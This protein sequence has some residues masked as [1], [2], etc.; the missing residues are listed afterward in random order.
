MIL[1][2]FS[3]CGFFVDHR[4]NNPSSLF[5]KTGHP[6]TG[7]FSFVKAAYAVHDGAANEYV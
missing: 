6:A 3:F 4:R 1:N 7:G 5:M 2:P